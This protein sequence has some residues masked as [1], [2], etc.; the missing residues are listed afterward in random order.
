MKRR[1]KYAE[2]Y[3]DRVLALA[4]FLDVGP[5]NIEVV[6][7]SN[8]IYYLNILIYGYGDEEYY[9]L[10][11]EE[12]DDLAEEMIE[13]DLQEDVLIF[14]EWVINDCIDE[15]RIK[16]D[17][18]Y[19]INEMINDDYSAYAGWFDSYLDDIIGIIKN[20]AEENPDD[21]A[22]WFMVNREDYENEEDYLE[23][24]YDEIDNLDI[25][26]ALEVVQEFNIDI[27][28]IA[29]KVTDDYI[30]DE[31]LSNPVDYFTGL[32]MEDQLH[33]YVDE[34]CVID[35]VISVDGRGHVIAS[36]DGAEEE[37]GDFFIYRIN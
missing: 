15:D 16:S 12:A 24:I 4:N 29:D 6:D 37:Q 21:Y 20:E 7:E 31:I 10:T 18:W 1:K 26:G 13:N 19:D 8:Y 2:E 14:S 32:G 5:D 17:F 30:E 22:D 27:V 35:T 9:V 25:D 11:D 36:Y 34:D 33:N 3:D 28:A 23:A